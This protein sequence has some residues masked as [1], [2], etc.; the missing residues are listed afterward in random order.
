M[1]NLKISQ[2]T[3]NVA[4]HFRD[5]LVIVGDPAGTPLTQKSELLNITGLIVNA[6]T[7]TSYT[8]LT[9]DYAKLVTHTNASAIAATLPQA[10]ATFPANWFMFVQN[11][12]AGAL[13]ITP[14]TSTI[15]GAT[16][17]VLNQ[18]EGALVVSDGTNYFTSRGKATG[19]VGGIGDVVG[20]ASAT[21]NALAR[22]DT[23][24]GKLIQDSPVT[25]DNDGAVTV[26]EIAA[27]STPASGKIAVYAKTDGKL[28]IKDDAGTETDLA[29]SGS[30]IGGST[31]S[32]DNAILRADGTGGS[33]AQASAVTISDTDGTMQWPANTG[34]K[35]KFYGDNY[36][37]GIESGSL[38]YW[39][40]DTHRFRTSGTSVSSGTVRMSLDADSL[41]INVTTVP[42]L[43]QFAAATG[44]KIQLHGNGYGIGIEAFNFTQWSNANFRWRTG[45][46]S[47]SSGTDIMGL[48]A[49]GVLHF[50]AGGTISGAAKTPSQITADQNNYN[51]GGNASRLQRWNTDAAR[52]IT[53][54]TFTTA[55]NDGQEH[56]I[57]NVGSN[58]IV[59][60]HE[61]TNS[62]AGNRFLSSTGADI[63]LSANQAADVIYDSATQRW[64]AFKRN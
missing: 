33:T 43:I 35:L 12:G 58:N 16:T 27:P 20:P 47:V 51:P 46:T 6:Q 29:G 8:Y 1:A 10:S 49:T 59:L 44:D 64:R 3:A 37:I 54:L 39:S 9:G 28:Y 18:N 34:D 31:G 4:R 40:Q 45:G 53:G 17:L 14:T 15:D 11:R 48:G 21:D 57:V 5:L 30:G 19:G 7:G 13:T 52:N 41:D 55:V 23:T 22:F 32:T 63:T 25:L 60:K 62:T 36:G 38:T 56:L 26:P 2:L 42:A 50:T 61:D 24:T